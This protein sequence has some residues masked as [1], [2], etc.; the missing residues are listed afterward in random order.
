MITKVK[1]FVSRKISDNTNEMSEAWKIQ[2]QQYKLNVKLKNTIK[3]DPVESKK[4]LID[5][6]DIIMR[7][8]SRKDMLPDLK[9]TVNTIAEE[10]FADK[11]ILENMVRTSIHDYS[12][13]IHVT[14]SM[15]YGFSYL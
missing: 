4:I 9:N 7:D 13:S 12:T 5:L 3:I 15:L 10:F 6:I 11:E 2:Q 1:H 8:P 14:N